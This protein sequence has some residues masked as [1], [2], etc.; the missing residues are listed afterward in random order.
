MLNHTL[1]FVKLCLT[2]SE[3]SQVRWLHDI[4]S[5]ID[6][7][8]ETNCVKIPLN[9]DYFVNSRFTFKIPV[10]EEQSLLTHTL[11]VLSADGVNVSFRRQYVDI[12]NDRVSEYRKT[13]VF[14]KIF[15]LQAGEKL[16]ASVSIPEL[17]YASGIDNDL[18]MVRLNDGV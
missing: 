12:P 1:L 9:G 4:Y 14:T 3:T 17:L 11:R 10:E 2:V 7:V 15:H 18:T 13:S 8:P 6:I 16:C 5:I